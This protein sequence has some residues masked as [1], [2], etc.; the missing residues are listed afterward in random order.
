MTQEWHNIFIDLCSSEH[1]SAPVTF[2]R[3][4]IR[5][6]GQIILKIICLEGCVNN[7]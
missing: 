4:D 5:K 3:N 7:L 6:H 2:A 1:A